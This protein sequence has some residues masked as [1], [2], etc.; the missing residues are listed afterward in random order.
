MVTRSA[1]AG[2]TGVSVTAGLWGSEEIKARITCHLLR[3]T[4]ENGL[5][6]KPA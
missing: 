6:D 2:F 3:G 1:A 4:E 5:G